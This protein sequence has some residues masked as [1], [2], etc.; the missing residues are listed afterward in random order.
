MR[1]LLCVLSIAVLASVSCA[2]AN[3][4]AMYSP[5]MNT[6]D[7]EIAMP[8][9]GFVGGFDALPNGNYLVNDGHAIRE[10]SASG[11]PDTT[12][13]SFAAP[14][15]GS[16][17]RYNPADGRVYFGESSTGDIFA[18]SYANPG[19]VGLVTNMPGDFD[20]DFREGQ[21]VHRRIG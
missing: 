1:R 20:M 18:F 12:L 9:G 15:F 10:I 8:S 16:F 19:N 5:G 14:V 2:S 4:A 17:V 13:Y 11:A 6:I 21:A 3:A 7:L